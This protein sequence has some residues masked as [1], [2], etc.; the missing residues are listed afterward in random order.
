[1]KIH[2]KIMDAFLDAAKYELKGDT[3]LIYSRAPNGLDIY[4]FVKI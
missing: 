4:T 3:L 1:M 2:S